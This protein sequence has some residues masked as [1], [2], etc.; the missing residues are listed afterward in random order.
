MPETI[1]I[2]H[3]PQLHPWNDPKYSRSYRA[4]LKRVDL[5]KRNPGTKPYHYSMNPKFKLVAKSKVELG[6]SAIKSFFKR[7]VNSPKHSHA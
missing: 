2:S 4:W 1:T 5:A 3:N 7:L 6:G